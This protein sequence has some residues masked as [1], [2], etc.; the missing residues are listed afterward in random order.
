[1]ARSCWLSHRLLANVRFLCPSPYPTVGDSMQVG[2]LVKSASHYVGETGIITKEKSVLKTES[3]W[4]YKQYYITM[5][6]V[7]WTFGDQGWF[8]PKVLEAI[9]K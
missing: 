1:M 7:E 8:F 9:C 6:H 2:D 3:S 5:Y 4:P